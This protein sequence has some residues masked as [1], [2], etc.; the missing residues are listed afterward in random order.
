[1][2]IELQTDCRKSDIL[3]WDALP[4]L[5]IVYCGQDGIGD[6][7]YDHVYDVNDNGCYQDSDDDADSDNDDNDD[8]DGDDDDDDYDFNYAND[9]NDDNDEDVDEVDDAADDIIMMK[10]IWR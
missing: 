8:D 6:S 1:M 3:I 5:C 9:D 7:S 10:L 4:S 2:D